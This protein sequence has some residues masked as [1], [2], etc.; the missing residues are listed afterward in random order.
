MPQPSQLGQAMTAH[1]SR[2]DQAEAAGAA[3]ASLLLG[4]HQAKGPAPSAASAGPAI[5]SPAGLAIAIAASSAGIAGAN[6]TGSAVQ[7]AAGPV[8][9]TADCGIKVAME[10][11]EAD[12]LASSCSNG[13]PQP[14][15]S[16][17]Q[18]GMAAATVA[19]VD[20]ETPMQV[21]PVILNSSC[22][23]VWMLL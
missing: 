5:A 23:I 11:Q 6:P 8:P 13:L 19:S 17:L 1:Y 15:K 12:Q 3:A 9:L 2:D 14:V 4:S 21:Q 10:M 20:A 7:P 16:S 22:S 18:Q